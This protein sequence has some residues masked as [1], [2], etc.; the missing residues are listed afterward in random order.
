M[1]REEAH[2]RVYMVLVFGLAHC[3]AIRNGNA[4]VIHLKQALASFRIVIIAW[5]NKMFNK[6]DGIPRRCLAS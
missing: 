6:G 4:Q 3:H 2:R 1:P 5:N